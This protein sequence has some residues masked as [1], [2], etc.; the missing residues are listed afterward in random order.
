MPLTLEDKERV[1]L[2]S[3]RTLKYAPDISYPYIYLTN[4][5]YLNIYYNTRKLNELDVFNEFH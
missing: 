2:H 5:Y 4:F 3:E 1:Q